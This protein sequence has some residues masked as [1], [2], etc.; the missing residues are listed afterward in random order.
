VTRFLV[1]T[2]AAAIACAVAL[3]AKAGFTKCFDI[4]ATNTV[5]TACL[6]WHE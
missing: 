5:V 1:A 2:V 3:P 4:A 6:P